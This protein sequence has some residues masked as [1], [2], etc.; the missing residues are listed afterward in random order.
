MINR[1]NL[2]SL[3]LKECNLDESMRSYLS[4]QSDNTLLSN[5]G[6]VCIRVGFYT[7]NK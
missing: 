7:I 6:F 4:Q 3:L 1:Y 5:S 2:I